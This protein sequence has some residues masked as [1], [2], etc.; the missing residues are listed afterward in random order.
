MGRDERNGGDHRG[1]E[2]R[3]E[4]AKHVAALIAAVTVIPG[5]V[6]G[7]A[8]LLLATM[9]PLFL[10]AYIEFGIVP[11]EAHREGDAIPGIWW[12]LNVLWLLGLLV[13][14][15]VLWRRILR[16]WRRLVRG[17]KRVVR[18]VFDIRSS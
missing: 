7:S 3:Q 4:G 5:L 8:F 6:F 14:T 15:I 10:G 1:R 17:W 11:W 12:L 18:T 13:G 16:G 9:W 2:Y